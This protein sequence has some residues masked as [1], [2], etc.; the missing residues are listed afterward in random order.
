LYTG[1]YVRSVAECLAK[2]FGG[3]YGVLR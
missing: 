2:G 1:S 3:P